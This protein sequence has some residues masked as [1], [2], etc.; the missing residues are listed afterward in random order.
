MAKSPI[1]NSYT[2]LKQN[3]KSISAKNV[4]IGL[5]LVLIGMILGSLLENYIYHSSMSTMSPAILAPSLSPSSVISPGVIY[6]RFPI[7]ADK[8]VIYLYPQESTKINVKLHLKA[9]LTASYPLY[10]TN[11]G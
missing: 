6:E 10:D 5:G 7:T 3:K 4:F 1:N 2:P 9:N 11:Q 8:P